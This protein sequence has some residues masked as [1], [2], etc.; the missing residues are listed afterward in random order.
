MRSH[1]LSPRKY[2]ETGRGRTVE[3]PRGA[4]L[5]LGRFGPHGDLCSST[6]VIA[7]PYQAEGHL[8]AGG[9]PYTPKLKL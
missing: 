8:K 1:H 5:W 3:N 9:T 6:P 2:G 4:R 7:V